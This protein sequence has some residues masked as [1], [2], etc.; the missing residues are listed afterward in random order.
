VTHPCPVGCDVPAPDDLTICRPCLADIRQALA[1]LPALVDHLHAT[2]AREVGRGAQNGGRAAEKPLPYD[3]RASRVG[4]IRDLEENPERHP[5][6]TL[7]SMSR[8]LLRR[9]E[10]IGTHAAAEEIHREIVGGT[11]RGWKAVDSPPERVYLGPCNCGTELHALP[12]ATAATCRDCSLV[13]DVTERR[14][15]MVAAMR[16]RLFTGAEIARLATHLGGSIDRDRCRK[17]IKVWATRKLIV[18]HGSSASGDPLYPFGETLDRIAAAQAK[19]D[20][21]RD[22]G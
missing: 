10:A 22:A 11:A 9:I 6:D 8:W 21:T 12:G 17:L 20:R 16:D 2:L 14:E 7:P 5:K 3:V 18:A 15:H 13:H 19:S 1:E 4:W